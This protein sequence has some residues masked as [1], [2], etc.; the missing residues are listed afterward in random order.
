MINRDDVI[1][2]L[3]DGGSLGHKPE[4]EWAAMLHDALHQT[5]LDE[6]KAMRAL[7]NLALNSGALRETAL[8]LAEHLADDINR[9]APD[10]LPEYDWDA[11]RK[12]MKECGDE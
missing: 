6:P 11:K 5:L 3:C 7:F 10:A 2:V 12:E 4:A 8:D 1:A 9:D